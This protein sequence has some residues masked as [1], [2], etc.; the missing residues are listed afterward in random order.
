MIYM[1]QLAEAKI[2]YSEKFPYVTENRLGGDQNHVIVFTDQ[3]IHLLRI[4]YTTDCVNDMSIDELKM[5]REMTSYQNGLY[6]S[7]ATVALDQWLMN[8]YE[9]EKPNPSIEDCNTIVGNY[10]ECDGTV[11]PF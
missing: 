11:V 10:T 9:C 6:E 5:T 1:C 4:A 2:I 7:E 8:L 3:Y